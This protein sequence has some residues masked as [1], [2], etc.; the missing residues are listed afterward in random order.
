MPIKVVK[1]IKTMLDKMGSA[2]AGNEFDKM[3][4]KAQ[5][6]THELLRD[7]A[8]NYLSNSKGKNSMPESHGRHLATLALSNFKEHVTITQRIL[9]ELGA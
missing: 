7:L 2:S 3:Y 6:E 4:I 1:H 5:L 8:E 9:G